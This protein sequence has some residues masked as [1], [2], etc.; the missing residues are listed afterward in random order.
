[1][2]SKRI[3]MWLT[4]EA[5]AIVAKAP[6]V[7]AEINRCVVA[8]GDF[9]RAVG[10]NPIH[11]DSEGAVLSAISRY[12]QCW[13]EAVPAL[14]SGEWLLICDALNSTWR[15]GAIA[16]TDIAHVLPLE[17]AE[18]AADGFGEKWGVDIPALADRIAAMRFCERAAIIEVVDR[19]WIAAA[20]GIK[21]HAELLA[22]A[23]ARMGSGGEQQ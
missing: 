12:S 8:Y 22:E 9:A 13:R 16:G 17:I 7:S 23:G 15:S 2:P 21:T 6:S 5:Q 18:T 11:P 14:A 4:D 1:M 20:A 3:S 10:A 19:F